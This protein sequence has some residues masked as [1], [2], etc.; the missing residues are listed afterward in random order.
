[1]HSQRIDTEKPA[2]LVNVK[3]ENDENSR[4]HIDKGRYAKRVRGF[5]SVQ[6]SLC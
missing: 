2:K 6:V 5:D 4:V 1:M 3:E